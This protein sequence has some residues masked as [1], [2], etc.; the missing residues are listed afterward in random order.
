MRRAG[1]AKMARGDHIYVHR[2]GGAYGHHGIDCGDNQVIHY[3]GKDWSNLRVV[4]KT[5]M[6]AFARGERVQV[7]NYD[8]LVNAL[9]SPQSR[10]HRTSYQISRLLNALHGIDVDAIDL[11][12]DGVVARAEQRLGERGFHI[13][14]YNCE[15][16]ATW[17]KTGIYNSEQINAALQLV[18]AS[19]ELASFAPHRFLLDV[20]QSV[21]DLLEGKRSG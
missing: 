11:S 21:L 5:S 15:H 10:C 4:R 12:P 8:S 17:C 18:F 1:D 9:R 6:D 14:L 2:F 19:P 16:F 7:R 3:T 20:H 13:I